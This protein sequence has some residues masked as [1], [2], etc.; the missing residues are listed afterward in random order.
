MD[1]TDLTL[2]ATAA[3]MVAVK[4]LA[5]VYQAANPAFYRRLG[6]TAAEILG[7]T[8]F[9]LFPPE[10]AALYAAN[11]RTAIASARAQQ[12]LEL[13]A[14]YEGLTWLDVAR[15]PILDAAGECTGVLFMAHDHIVQP[16]TSAS[17]LAARRDGQ[18]MYDWTTEMATLSEIGL[19]IT[20]G[21]KMKPVLQAILEGCRR[22]LPVDAWYVALYDRA[23]YTYQ[24]PLFYDQGVY[25]EL[26]PIHMQDRA[27]LTRSVIEGGR[28]VHI[29]DMHDAST[30]RAHPTIQVATS[31]TRSYLG[32]PLLVRGEVIGVLSVQNIEPAVYSERHV[33]LLEIIATQ[34]A[35]AVDNARLYEAAQQ[36]LAE[37]K[38]VEVALLRA[39]EHLETAVAESQRLAAVAEAANQAK[40]EFLANMSHELRTPMNAVIGLTTL[41]LDTPLTAEQR[42]FA[43]I[44]RSSGDA[45]LS[46][47]NDVLDFSKIEAG[48]LELDYAPIDLVACVEETLDLFSVAAQEK[49]IDLA[50]IFDAQ[51]PTRIECD[52]SRL[53]QILVNLLGN[54]LKFTHQ[55]EIV[56]SISP[57]VDAAEPSE[58]LHFAVRDTGIGIAPDRIGRLFQSFSQADSS[59]TRRYGG[60]GLGL[61]ISKRLS[62]LMGGEMAVSSQHG[63]G[64]E[65]WFT[66]RAKPVQ[67][68]AGQS[69]GNSEER[70]GLSAP[71]I[72]LDPNPLS[73]RAIEEWLRRWGAAFVSVDTA[74]AALTALRQAV[75]NV[76]VLILDAA[77]LDAHWPEFEAMRTAAA[78]P[79]QCRIVR[80]E[81]RGMSKPPAASCNGLGSVTRPV[82]RN[83]LRSAIRT[84]LRTSDVP[85]GAQQ[86][87]ELAQPKIDATLALRQPLRIL[88]V[89]DNITNQRVAQHMLKRLGYT[90]IITGDG[91]EAIDVLTHER[92]DV[93]LMD[94]HMPG[95]DGLEATR[96][97]REML[98][99][100]Q[101]PFIVAMTAAA[102]LEDELACRLAGMNVV[103]TKPVRL[104]KLQWA[105]EQ[106]VRC[107]ES[108]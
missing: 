91:Q 12:T 35:V 38:Q 10:T 77:V 105:L 47:I 63:R 41:L 74:T 80:I 24:I 65:F 8:D 95:M 66:I 9:E 30:A 64:S 43:T 3:E 71:V 84:A 15:S 52:Y 99:A 79:A 73:R 16:A 78:D 61:A 29:E 40:S 67:P 26:P 96:R 106:T 4:N 36:E 69:D 101:Q 1:A 23:T 104:E 81:S 62:E 39:N 46:V 83:A 86:T 51:T 45:L 107:D 59:T 14:C 48:K 89:E 85:E 20:S 5:G 102:T 31:P 94:L 93:V 60:T 34:A 100:T 82:K 49:G 32:T 18:A 72:L 87:G 90:P 53:R 103:I 42:E 13:F 28:T 27:S 108:N 25:R 44:I 68:L 54:A 58:N 97:I 70:D 19:A 6:R 2:F 57:V 17:L 50:V 11:D 88:L 21:L 98:P 75:E 22:V 7:H 55:G 37:R 56:L 76:P 33:R 92:F